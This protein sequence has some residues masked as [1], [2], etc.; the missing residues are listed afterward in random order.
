MSV[1]LPEEVIAGWKE[2]EGPA[3]LT[4]VS[5]DGMPNAVYV[6]AV[7]MTDDGRIAVTDNYFDKTKANIDRGAAA[8]VLFIT[9]GHKAYQVKGKL[10]YHAAGP[11]YDWMLTWA[12]AKHPR[13][14]VAVLDAAEVYHGAQRLA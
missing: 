6:A 7:N 14:G 13:K 5:Q 1:S 2:R 10:E 4:T 9:A 3:V 8:A 12:N 11:L